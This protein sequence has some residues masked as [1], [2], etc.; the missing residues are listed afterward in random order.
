MEKTLKRNSNL[1]MCIAELIVG[2]LLLIN[3]VGF[4]RGIII[5]FGIPLTLQGIGSIVG[6]IRR[7]HPKAIYWPRVSL[8]SAAVC[9]ACSAPDG[10]SP[11][12]RC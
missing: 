12:S 10:S 4:T 8:W 11:H 2:V 9:S 1:L 6:Y 5:A 7:K 3:P